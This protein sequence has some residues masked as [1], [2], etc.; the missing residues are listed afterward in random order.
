MSSSAWETWLVGAGF[1]LIVFF[2]TEAFQQGLRRLQAALQRQPR[3]KF[4]VYPLGALLGLGAAA[5]II[6]A[7][8]DFAASRFSYD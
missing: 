2:C 8:A 3:L 6:N 1:L 4:V 5:L 7:L